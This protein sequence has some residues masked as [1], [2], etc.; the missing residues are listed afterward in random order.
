MKAKIFAMA[1]GITAFFASTGSVVG[2][3]SLSNLPNDHAVLVNALNRAGVEVEV[4]PIDDKSCAMNDGSYVPEEKKLVIC[5]ETSL[6]WSSNGLDTLRHESQHVLQDCVAGDGLG[7]YMSLYFDS[8]KSLEAFAVKA[9]DR[10]K[11]NWIV[12]TYSKRG[13]TVGVILMEVEAFS[14]AASVSPAEIAKSISK[15]CSAE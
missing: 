6:R 13:E 9:L 7:G 11:L 4:N 14:V 8:P 1:L 5:G 12:D 2:A 10:Q 3:A 15:T